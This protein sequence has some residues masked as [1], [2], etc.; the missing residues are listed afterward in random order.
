MKKIFIIKMELILYLI[1]IK[2]LKYY[3]NID[4]I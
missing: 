2:R 3:F 4:K 1:A